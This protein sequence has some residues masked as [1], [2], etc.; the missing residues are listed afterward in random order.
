MIWVSKGL[1]VLVVL[2]HLYFF[3]LESIAWRKVAGKTFR[4]TPEAV[5]HTAVMASNQGA[6]NALLALGLIIG[7]AHPD[8]TIGFWFRA[9]FLF[10]VVVAGI[11]GGA[12]VS[13]RI[14]YVQALPALLGLVATL[15]AR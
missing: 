12:T 10:A 13:S 6:Y 11:W 3:W 1:S 8:P 15:L 2:A 7:I 5:E 4:M 14:F 9:Y